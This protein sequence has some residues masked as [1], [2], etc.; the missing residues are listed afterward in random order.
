MYSA[1]DE[2]LDSIAFDESYGIIAVASPLVVHLYRPYKAAH[3]TI[4]KVRD[5]HALF[6]AKRSLINR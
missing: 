4:P 1:G 2:A 3:S 5:H 6:F